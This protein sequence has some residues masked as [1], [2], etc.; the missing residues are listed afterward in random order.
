MNKYILHLYHQ[1]RFWIE[2]QGWST[3]NSARATRYTESEARKLG[4]LLHAEAVPA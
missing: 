2:G 3:T 1:N 4:S